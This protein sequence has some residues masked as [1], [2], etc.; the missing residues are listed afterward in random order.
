ME[1]ILNDTP[2]TGTSNLRDCEAAAQ[3]LQHAANQEFSPGISMLQAVTDQRKLFAELS[4][5][6][7]R[8]L[9]EHL[10][11]MFVQTV[12]CDWLHICCVCVSCVFFSQL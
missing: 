1:S 6:F 7:A 10:S 11:G 8:R 2:L 4:S 5:T 3:L 12:S 9:Y